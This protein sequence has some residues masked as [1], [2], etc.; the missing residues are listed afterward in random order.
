MRYRVLGSLDVGEQGEIELGPPKQPTL[1][2]RLLRARNR[3]VAVADLIDALWGAAAPATAVKTVQVY[4]SQLRG[5]LGPDEI[6]RHPGGYLLRAGADDLDAA[7]FER[8]LADGRATAESGNTLPVTSDGSSNARA[9]STSAGSD[10]S[11]EPDVSPTSC[12]GNTARVN[13]PRGIR[14]TVDA[15]G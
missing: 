12:A 9:P 4:I 10:A 2:V 1:L 7:T 8:L 14:P 11:D 3:V 15:I 13:H 5:R 6:E